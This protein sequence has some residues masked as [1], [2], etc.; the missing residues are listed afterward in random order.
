MKRKYFLII[1]F[2][3][4][5]L[6]SFTLP[7]KVKTI[8]KISSDM[9]PLPKLEDGEVY[10]SHFKTSLNDISSIGMKFATFSENNEHGKLKIKIEDGEKVVTE[11]IVDVEDLKDNEMYYI[12]FPKQKMSKNKDYKILLSYEEYYDDI[13]LT[14]W[15][16]FINSKSN[17]TLKNGQSTNMAIYEEVSGLK[18]AYHISFYIALISIIYFIYVITKVGDHDD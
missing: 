4:L 12:D 17:Y 10:E 9:Y 3:I 8:E 7:V 16:N 15:G 13:S 18:Y 2:I 6:F 1:I 11:Q 5:M 14:L